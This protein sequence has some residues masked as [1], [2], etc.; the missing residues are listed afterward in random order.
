M[1]VTTFLV[2]TFFFFFLTIKVY[3]HPLG[4]IIISKTTY[5]NTNENIATQPLDAPAHITSTSCI[6]SATL[7]N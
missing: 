4:Y 6:H 7:H 3:H 5:T 2:Y 1:K